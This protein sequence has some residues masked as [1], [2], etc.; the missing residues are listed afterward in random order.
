MDENTIR[1]VLAPF[2]LGKMLEAVQLQNGV[3]RIVLNA[4]RATAERLEPLRRG[5]ESTLKDLPGVTAASILLTAH[6]AP[7]AATAP[8]ALRGMKSVIAVASGKGGVGKST[9]AVN[10]AVALA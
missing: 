6:C 4:D 5:I 7:P 9:V 1:A 8:T 3:V 2:N 10:L